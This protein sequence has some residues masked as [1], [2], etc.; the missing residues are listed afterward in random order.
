MYKFKA[1]KPFLEAS[2][3]SN[4]TIEESGNCIW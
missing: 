2:G 4:K 1:L 3:I